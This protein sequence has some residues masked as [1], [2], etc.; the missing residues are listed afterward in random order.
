MMRRLHKYS[1][2]GCWVLPP[3]YSA[4]AVDGADRAA[5]I[6]ISP[7]MRHALSAS[8]WVHVVAIPSSV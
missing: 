6:A 3:S 1:L 8:V 4:R 7:T 2:E 5:S